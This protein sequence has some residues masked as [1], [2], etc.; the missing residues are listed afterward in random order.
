MCSFFKGLLL[1]LVLPAAKPCKLLRLRLPPRFP[2]CPRG[3]G[4]SAV[5]PGRDSGPA[6]CLPP[7][8]D[9]NYDSLYFYW[10]MDWGAHLLPK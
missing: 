10:S 9:T 4:D 5:Y 8:N 2:V 3:D 7:F 1:S 6:T